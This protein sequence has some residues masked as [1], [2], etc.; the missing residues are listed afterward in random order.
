[1]RSLPAPM[2]SLAAPGQPTPY[3]VISAARPTTLS[4]KR[5]LLPISHTLEQRGL[6]MALPPM[7]LSAFQQARHFTPRTA[8]RYRRLASQ[9]PFV[10]AL[11]IGMERAPATGVR[12]A[13]LSTDDP[14]AGEWS[15]LVLGP[16]FSAALVARDLGDSGAEPDRRFRY[17]VTHD[18][19]LVVAAARTLVDRVVPV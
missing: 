8:D 17:A 14:L 10:A 6:E 19:A 15:V 11:G 18:R 3:D 9:L 13:A 12:G 1:V 5:L 7:L 16:H 4:T 2:P